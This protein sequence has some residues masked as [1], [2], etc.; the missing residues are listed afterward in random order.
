[1]TVRDFIWAA[2][3]RPHSDLPVVV[4][5]EPD[6]PFYTET[7]YFPRDQDDADG[8]DSAGVERR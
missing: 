5:V 6:E 3:A 8:A 7:P 2:D 4:F 1:V